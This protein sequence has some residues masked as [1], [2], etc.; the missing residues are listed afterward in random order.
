MTRK[1]M[2]PPSPTSTIADVAW[3]VAVIHND[4]GES[5]MSAVLHG[6]L[7]IADIIVLGSCIATS[8]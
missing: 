4:P 2:H 5:S 6:H 8:R 1:T 3:A 7:E